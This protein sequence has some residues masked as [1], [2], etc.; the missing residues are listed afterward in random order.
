MRRFL[1]PL[2]LL[3]VGC[4]QSPLGPDGRAAAPEAWGVG[5]ADGGTTD[6]PPQPPDSVDTDGDGID[7][8]IDNCPGTPNADQADDDGDGI[9]DACGWID[10]PPQEDGDSDGDG[11]LDSEDVCPWTFDPDQEDADGNGI[12]DACER[13]DDGGN[14]CVID[15]DPGD[16]G[17]SG[18]GEEGEGKPEET[19]QADGEVTCVP[20]DVDPEGDEDGDSISNATDNCIWGFNPLQEDANGYGRGDVCDVVIQDPADDD[21]SAGE[22]GPTGNNAHDDAHDDSDGDG[23]A[24]GEDNCPETANDGQTDSDGDGRGNK[25]DG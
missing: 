10:E 6:E 4:S 12:G 2:G 13:P 22:N 18:G 15:G 3:W 21:G 9:G 1:L 17:G 25:C 11:W 23:V 14:P 24:N 7:D 19:V 16:G 20:E 8:W 5:A